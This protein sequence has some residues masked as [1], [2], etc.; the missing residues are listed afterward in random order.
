MSNVS[1]AGDAQAPLSADVFSVAFPEL[2]S[3]PTKKKYCEPGD[4][5]EMGKDKARRGIPAVG[6]PEGFLFFGVL[7]GAYSLYITAEF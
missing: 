7:A 6:V 1:K 3:V 4:S 2:L 5:V